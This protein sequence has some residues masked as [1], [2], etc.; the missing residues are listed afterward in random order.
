MLTVLCVLKSGGVY[1]AE[2]VGKLHRAVTRNLSVPHQFW[3]LSDVPVPS[4]RIPL[5]HNWPGWWSKVELFRPGVYS[6]PTVYLDLD[7][8]IVRNIDALA[9]LRCEFGMLRG[10]GRKYYVGSGV[11]FFSKPR[12]DI[13]DAFLRAPDELMSRY[14]ANPNNEHGAGNAHRGDQ[15]FIYDTV[16][17]KAIA[18]LTDEVPGLIECY[19]KTV[20]EKLPRSCGVVCFKGKTK[21]PAAMQHAW[22]A[23]NWI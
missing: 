20:E 23:E 5:E 8:V 3:C 16:G 12:T 14:E 10:F 19:P 9:S 2:W 22:C 4:P 11:M 6:G 17:N 21:P 15:A 7:T 1:D 18:R 13:Y